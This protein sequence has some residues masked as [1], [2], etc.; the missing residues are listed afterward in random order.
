[1]TDHCG[2][3]NCVERVDHCKSC[4]KT[5]TRVFPGDRQSTQYANALQ[6]RFGGGYG[7]Y[8]D[9]TYDVIVCKECADLM[10]KVVPWLQEYGF[11]A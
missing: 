4:N 6:I 2:T 10:F 3:C 8:M 11:D 5:L 7:M 1:M 9:A